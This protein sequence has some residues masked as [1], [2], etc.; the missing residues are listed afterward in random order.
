VADER[1]I[2]KSARLMVELVIAVALTR[3]NTLALFVNGES[4]P[5]AGVGPSTR[6]YRRRD[7]GNEMSRDNEILRCRESA[8]SGGGSA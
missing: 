8:S 4:G 7:V 6:W 2:E 1:F 3:L 5:V